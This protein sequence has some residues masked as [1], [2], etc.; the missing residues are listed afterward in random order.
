MSAHLLG[1]RRKEKET[2]DSTRPRGF[3]RRGRLAGPRGFR[4]GVDV[5]EQ[6]TGCTMWDGCARVGKREKSL[7]GL[8]LRQKERLDGQHLNISPQETTATASTPA[9]EKPGTMRN[10]RCD[11]ENG[12]LSR[13]GVVVQGRSRYL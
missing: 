7:F 9:G 3:K 12:G 8:V 6:V 1:I 5:V 13:G 11:A 10:D 2:I 4:V